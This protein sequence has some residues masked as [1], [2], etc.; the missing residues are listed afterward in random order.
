M[1]ISDT[2]LEACLKQQ[3][4]PCEGVYFLLLNKKEVCNEYIRLM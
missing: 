2:L 3:E 1:E 4:L